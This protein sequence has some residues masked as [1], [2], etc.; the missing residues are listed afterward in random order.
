MEN[1]GHRNQG[2]ENPKQGEHPEHRGRKGHFTAGTKV[3]EA[4]SSAETMEPGENGTRP[5]NH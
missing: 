4:D 1:I 5:S 3:E 2:S